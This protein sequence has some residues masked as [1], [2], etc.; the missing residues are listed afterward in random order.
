MHCYF[1]LVLDTVVIEAIDAEAV[2]D[3]A[4]FAAA[5]RLDATEREQAFWAA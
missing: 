4:D 2:D 3:I 1:G 5:G